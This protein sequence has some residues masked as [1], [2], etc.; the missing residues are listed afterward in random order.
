MSSLTKSK[1]FGGMV[2][3]IAKSTEFIY[4]GFEN[5]YHV[6]KRRNSEDLELVRE[7][8]WIDKDSGLAYHCRKDGSRSLTDD[9]AKRVSKYAN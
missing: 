6:L 7:M 3:K 1:D 5:G 2:M 4:G 8:K 9:S